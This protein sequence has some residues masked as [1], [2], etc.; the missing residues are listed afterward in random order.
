M[1]EEVKK[2][3][4]KTEKT[5]EE[6]KAEEKLKEEALLDE[7]DEFEEFALGDVDPEVGCLKNLLFGDV[8]LATQHG[9]P[10][11]GGERKK[12]YFLKIFLFVECE[13]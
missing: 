11:Q 4:K 2:D 3:E 13:S 6:K 1:P 8:K 5:S 7:E 10:T 9:R 12:R